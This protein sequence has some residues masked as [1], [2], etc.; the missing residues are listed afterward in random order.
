VQD[1]GMVG[2]DDVTVAR[3]AQAHDLFLI[4]KDTGMAEVAELLGVKHFL[5]SEAWIA[6]MVDARLREDG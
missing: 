1:I 4:T 5:I 3:H 6:K 2:K